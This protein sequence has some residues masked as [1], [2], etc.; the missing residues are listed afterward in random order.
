ARTVGGLADLLDHGH[1]GLLVK[2]A[3]PAEF[4]V[5]LKRLADNDSLSN[6]I[7]VRARNLLMQQY[8]QTV[9]ARRY[10]EL[11][12]LIVPSRMIKNGSTE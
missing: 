10:V 9:M 11:C 2:S 5:N 12:L 1:A 4:I 6:A 8:S 7:A 3:D